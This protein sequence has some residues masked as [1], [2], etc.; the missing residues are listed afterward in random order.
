MTASLLAAKVAIS[1]IDLNNMS[2]FQEALVRQVT[3]LAEL[4][5]DDWAWV[6]KYRITTS[7]SY[8]VL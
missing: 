7:K 4:F 5:G 8:L 6:S 1:H 3:D 2:G